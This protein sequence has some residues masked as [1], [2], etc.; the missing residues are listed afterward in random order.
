M[1]KELAAEITDMLFRIYYEQIM[2][3]D[4]TE[5][6]ISVGTNF[7]DEN[8]WNILISDSINYFNRIGEHEKSERLKRI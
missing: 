2:E 8:Y 3:G 7:N 6:S 4:L 5:K 1:R